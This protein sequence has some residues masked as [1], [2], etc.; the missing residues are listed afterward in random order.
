MRALLTA[1]RD[2]VRSITYFSPGL[3]LCGLIAA[4][5]TELVAF[6]VIQAIPWT[7][8]G[9]PLET[10]PYDVPMVEFG[11]NSVGVAFLLL[12]LV[13]VLAL[14]RR[15][16][17][18]YEPWALAGFGLCFVGFAG[19]VRGVLTIDGRGGFAADLTVFWVAFA[20]FAAGMT[21]AVIAGFRL[22]GSPRRGRALVLCTLGLPPCWSLIIHTGLIDPTP[23]YK[24]WET[25]VVLPHFTRAG[26]VAVDEWTPVVELALV[27]G[28]LVR[29]YEGE[30]ATR[31]ELVDHLLHCAVQME[32][33]HLNV[34][35]GTGPLIP[36]QMLLIRAD[37]RLPMRALLEVI[38]T[39]ARDD[40]KIWKI[41]L[42]TRFPHL[43]YPAAIPAYLFGVRSGAASEESELE[44]R[45]TRWAATLYTEG[46]DRVLEIGPDVTWA[47]FVALLDDQLGPNSSSE[48]SLTRLQ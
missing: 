9:R 32:K 47:T 16:R 12:C 5:F 40:V 38:E 35:S 37:E 7:L 6:L 30:L 23:L 26:V 33:E 36:D 44:A 28:T 41:G 17:D 42:G 29:R 48:I 43:P 2:R 25:D 45:G 31:S 34:E 22:W 27:E 10:V 20:A 18:R 24:S 4:L 8:H 14:E 15:I 39:C 13:S 19:C 21:C 3:L 46:G 1:L 11:F